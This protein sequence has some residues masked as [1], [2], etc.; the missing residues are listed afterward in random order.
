MNRL[1][2]FLPWSITLVGFA[3]MNS[4]YPG[5]PERWPLHYNA[6]GSPDGWAIKSYSHAFFPLYMATGIALVFELTAQFGRFLTSGSSPGR[7]R[8]R[9]ANLD[10]L[11][12]ISS[13]LAL[14]LAYIAYTLPQA[15]GPGFLVA[16]VIGLLSVLILGPLWSFRASYQDIV[17]ISQ[18]RPAGYRGLYYYDPADPRIWVPKLTGMGWTPNFAHRSAWFWTAAMIAIPFLIVVG[19]LIH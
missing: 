18:N 5:L 17:E 19:T 14:F 11:R 1:L 13:A 8:A 2:A 16:P 15:R 9:Q 3:V 6:A 7:G 4:I 12:I 10:C